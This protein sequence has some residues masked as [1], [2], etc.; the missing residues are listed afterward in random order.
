VNKFYQYAL[1]SEVLD[2]RMKPQY[3]FEMILRWIADRVD[4]D[5]LERMA[6]EMLHE[7]WRKQR[8]E[9]K[10]NRD[11]SSNNIHF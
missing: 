11:D 3:V 4:G 5:T 2:N 10:E 9:M 6:G 1:L 8:E 7:S